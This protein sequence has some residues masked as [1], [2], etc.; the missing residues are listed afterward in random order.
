MPQN[1]PSDQGLHYLQ[2]VKPFSKTQSMTYLKINLTL[3][4]YNVWVSLFSLKWINSTWYKAWRFSQDEMINFIGFCFLLWELLDMTIPR[5]VFCLIWLI[6]CAEWSESEHFA[7]AGRNS[8]AWLVP[9]TFGACQTKKCLRTYTKCAASDHPAHAQSIIRAFAIHSYIQF[10]S[11][12]LTADS[13]GSDQTAH[14]RS[15]IWV[16]PVRTWP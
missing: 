12:I 4:I 13:E 7:H 11:M 1:A 6:G 9:F 10:Y 16:F 2:I 5:Q 15:L 3:P 14:P 8:F